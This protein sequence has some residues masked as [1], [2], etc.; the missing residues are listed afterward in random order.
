MNA[1]RTPPPE[2]PASIF[3]DPFVQVF[4]FLCLFLSLVFGV[5]E[6]SLFSLMLLATGLGAFLWSRLSLKG[7]DCTLTVDRE[8]LFPSVKS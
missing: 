7:L 2:A 1:M 8:R 6:L 3:L 4:L 5:A